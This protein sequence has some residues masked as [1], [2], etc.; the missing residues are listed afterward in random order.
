MCLSGGR[1][2]ENCKQTAKNENLKIKK[3]P[4][5][6]KRILALPTCSQICTISE[7]QPFTYFKL[8]SNGTPCIPKEEAPRDKLFNISQ[9][10]G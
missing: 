7:L 2:F 8:F 4:A 3:N 5:P 9:K 1:F 10:I 6:L